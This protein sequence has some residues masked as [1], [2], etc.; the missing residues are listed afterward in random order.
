MSLFYLVK[1]DMLIGHVLPLGCFKLKLQNL[2][3]LDCGSKFARFE[4]S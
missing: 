3:H 4:S 2:F 1:L